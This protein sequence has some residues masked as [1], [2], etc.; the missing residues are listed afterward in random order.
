[1]SDFD[2]E[3]ADRLIRY[4][5]IDSQSD[6]DSPTAP[7]TAIQL[8]MQRLLVTELQ[9]MG[10]E[11]VRLTAYG[12]VLATIPG[13]V[14]GPTVGFLAHV[15]TA[16]QF[17]AQGVKPRII[18][19][20]NGGAITYPDAPGL[21]LTPEAFPYLAQKVGHDIITASGLTLLG[22]DDKAGVAI[23]MT[24]ARHMLANPDV[25]RPRLRLAFTP[26]EEIGRGVDPRLPADLGAD[27]AYTFDGGALGEIEFETFS[28][29]GAV[30]TIRGV[31]IHP[32]YATGKL[33]NAI[34]L[35]SKIIQTLPQATL[36][37]ETT[38]GRD[39]FIHA[40]D[41]DGGASEMRIKFILRD[42][43]RD[44]LAAKGALLRQVCD[45]VAATE[46]RAEITCTITPQYRNMRYWLETDMTPVDL[47]RDA[48]RSL[49]IDPLSVPIRG[50][51]D[52][53]RLTEMGVP[54]PNLFTGMQNIHGPLEWIS[55]QDMAVATRL[56]LAVAAHAATQQ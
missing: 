56:C 29:D 22:A 10:A 12:A 44:G 11:D 46:P 50:G 48:A 26:D 13:T 8:D 42:F 35:A 9:Q 18:R 16:P 31:S 21:I 54:C 27:F 53:S 1:M 33:V 14:E 2:A 20:Y 49:G 51:T 24:A 4:C 30:V 15:D 28:A 19:G 23:V 55:V 45:A 32:G 39:G 38:A 52:G 5:A 6:A 40:T 36:T 17:N 41:M 34:H 43:E 3:L 25:A 7:S 47:A 37:P